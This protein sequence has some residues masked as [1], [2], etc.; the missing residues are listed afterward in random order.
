MIL[1]RFDLVCPVADGMVTRLPRVLR[2]QDRVR[3]IPNGIQIEVETE[4]LPNDIAAFSNGASILVAI[5]RLSGEKC[6]SVL[7]DAFARLIQTREQICLVIVG[8]GG[9][10]DALARQIEDLDLAA[11]VMLAGYRERPRKWLGH[12]AA[13]V[14]SSRTEGLPMV[15]L[16]ALAA[17]LPVVS[18]R[19]GQ[20]PVVAADVDIRLVDPGDARALCQNMAD[21]LEFGAEDELMRRRQQ[22]VAQRFSAGAMAKAYDDAYAYAED[23]AR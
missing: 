15:L 1:R 2:R 19:V 18:T 21:A 16:E 22:V 6:F 13:L 12:C 20:I 3:V 14:I 10:R 9:E 11:S 8:A 17:G 4:R 23:R 7:I 5:G